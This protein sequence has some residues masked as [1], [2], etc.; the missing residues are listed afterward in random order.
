MSQFTNS[1]KDVSRNYSKYDKWEQA[2]ADKMA[3]KEWLVRNLDVPPDKVELTKIKAQA[4]IRATEMMDKRSENNCE[5]VEQVMGIFSSIALLPI[6]FGQFPAIKF[7][8]KKMNKKNKEEL[9]KLEKNFPKLPKVKL[10]PKDPRLIIQE[11]EKN[12]KWQEIEKLRKKISKTTQK[13]S[14]IVSFGTIGVAFLMGIGLILW[15]NEKQKEASR[16]GRFQAKQKELKDVENFIVYTP[17]QLAQAEEI[18]KTIP[19]K[20][21]RNSLSQAIHEL[22][23]MG[24]SVTAYKRWAKQKDPKELEKLKAVNLSSE[25]L[26]KANEDKELITNTVAQ[27]NIKA[28]EFSENLENAYDTLGMLSFLLA[29]PLGFGINKI[30]SMAKVSPKIRGIVSTL[31]PAF[32]AL[33]IQMNGTFEQK[34]AAQVGR[35]YARKD[36]IKNPSQ[37]MAFSDEEMAQANGVKAPKQKQS[38]FEK[39]G[40]SFKFLAD[41]RKQKKEYKNYKEKVQ[42]HNE[43]LQKAFK[44]IETTDAQK[45]E[46]KKLQTNVFRAFDEVDEMSQRYSEDIEASTDIAKS[47]LT[48]VVQLAWMGGV[49]LLG[50]GIY[51]GK[52]SLAKPLKKLSDICFKNE[53]TLKQSINKFYDSLKAKGKNEPKEFQKA[54]ISGKLRTYFRKPENKESLTNFNKMRK[55]FSKIG[56]EGFFKLVETDNKN[57]TFKQIMESLFENHFK[58]TKIA[59]WGRN[60]T[61][62]AMKPKMN[63]NM[64]KKFEKEIEEAIKKNKPFTKEEI[65]TKKKEL[66]KQ[67]EFFG[68]DFNYKNYKTLINTGIVAGIPLLAPL[69]AIPYMFNAW[70]TDIQ[71]KAGKIGVMKA[72]ENL[73][74]P[75]IFANRTQDRSL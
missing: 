68:L 3:K 27:I 57:V 31:V 5:N 24:Q 69:F 12:P 61:M 15:G 10:D 25:E 33:G 22:K 30:L 19:D 44:Q 42:K 18:A 8:D 4:V 70:L 46:A 11:L 16:I 62:E 50:A 39:I 9:A 13:A 73:D 7:L 67:K 66:Q 49:G 51:K 63:S 54:L 6:L 43:K 37:L 29:V 75:R 14:N 20:K 26:L 2:Q 41:Y 59:K 72:M 1:I 23:E 28:E 60:F 47:V 32:T 45:A 34:N 58:Q 48:N 55:E 52:V 64:Q 71:K 35:Y 17:E 74:D 53:S 56:Q 38:L 40:K 65:A 21:E 36:L